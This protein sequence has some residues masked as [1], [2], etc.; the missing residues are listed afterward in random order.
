MSTI[1]N[2][3]NVLVPIRDG[4]RLATDV[5]EWTRRIHGR[6]R[7]SSELIPSTNSDSTRSATA[8]LFLP[9]HRFRLEGSSSN[10]PRFDR[11][12]TLAGRLPRSSRSI[13]TRNQSHLP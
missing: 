10:F 5:I 11:N 12:R 4:V 1:L 8:N 2:E 6:R 9:V 7:N 3:K 13:S